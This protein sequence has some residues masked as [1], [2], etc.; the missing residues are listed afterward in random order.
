MYVVLVQFC[1]LAVIETKNRAMAIVEKLEQQLDFP[2]KIRIHWTGCPNSC[3]QV[4]VA[5]IGL[6]G[7]PA[8][9]DGKATE[10]VRVFLGGTIGE[11][12]QLASQFE[13]GIACDESILLPYLRNIMTEK[14]GATPKAGVLAE[15]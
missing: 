1:G 14:F 13:K 3:G 15:A 2:K 11:N 12:P 9:L 8:K 6:M 5:D 10:G 7:G 4:Q